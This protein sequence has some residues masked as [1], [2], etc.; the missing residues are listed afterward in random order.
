MV[1]EYESC[2]I[3]PR[4]CGVNR[5]K[6]ERGFCGET[7]DLRVAWAGLHFGEEPPITGKG[8]SG[9]IFV[10]GCNLRCKFCQNFQISQD[11]M[12]RAVDSKE[13]AAIALALEK[14]GAENINVVTGSHA[15]PAIASGLR[16]ARDAGL[17]VPIL[18]NSSAYENPEALDLLDG[19]V[20]VWL[21]DL[22]TLNEDLAGNVFQAADYPLAA[23]KAIR[24][25]AAKS[26]LVLEHPDETA[27][28][29]GRITSGVI[30]RHLAL[31][32]RL[33]DTELV[34]KWFS[35]RLAKRAIL[36][37]MTQYTPV[38]AS[39]HAAGID[40]FP[41]RPFNR[42]EYDRLM[43]LVGE[44]DIETGFYQELVEDT[45]WLPDFI[46][47]QPFSSSLARPVW[48]WKTGFVH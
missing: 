31:P 44:L 13:F 3:C 20:T 2:A 35:S 34:L 41:D 24:H 23:K 28:P 27:Y 42:D 39:P 18:W 19:L 32:G 36:S 25:M 30:V 11:G 33:G 8:G 14:A 21:P 37:L 16:A 46:R 4:A 15:I 29:S 9:T 47:T 40:A 5:N 10:T 38:E 43:A 48:H 12:G 6:G 26:P 1:T 7:A 22:K 45:D 17:T